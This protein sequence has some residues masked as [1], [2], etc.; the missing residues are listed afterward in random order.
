MIQPYCSGYYLFPIRKG[1]GSL[2]GFGSFCTVNL[3]KLATGKNMDFSYTVITS[4][5]YQRIVATSSPLPVAKLTVQRISGPES[6]QRVKVY[7]S[8]F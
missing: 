6:E 1:L 7:T 3:V 2:S 4:D 5:L 8:S